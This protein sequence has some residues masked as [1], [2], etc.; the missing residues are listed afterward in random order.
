[1]RH[2]SRKRQATKVELEAGFNL[3]AIL[4]QELGSVE[5][6][7]DYVQLRFDGPLVIFH[8]WPEVFREEGSY[9]FGEPEYRDVLC[10]LIGESVS[11]A[12]VEEGEAMEIAFEGGGSVRV[13][14]RVED[15]SGPEGGSVAYADGN[16]E[17]LN[18]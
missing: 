2:L 14:L 11:A 10:S 8:E 18:F 5:F 3:E 7:Q 9:A 13:S 17:V 6:V 15:L 4:G 1:M 16:G 12:T